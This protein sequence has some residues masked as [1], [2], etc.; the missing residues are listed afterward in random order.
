MKCILR[1]QLL[2]IAYNIAWS[3]D[4][5]RRHCGEFAECNSTDLTMAYNGMCIQYGYINVNI[6]TY[7]NICIFA[8]IYRC[9]NAEF[10]YS[11]NASATM[12]YVYIRRDVCRFKSAEHNFHKS[13]TPKYICLVRRYT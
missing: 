13:P 12:R 4:D 3:R 10:T 1:I 8:C 11:F 2:Y 6:Y 9:T 5:N 7:T